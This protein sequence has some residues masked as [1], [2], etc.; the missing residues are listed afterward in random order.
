[1]VVEPPFGGMIIGNGVEIERFEN[2]LP[3]AS[4]MFDAEGILSC[5][6]PPLLSE[7]LNESKPDWFTGTGA[8]VPDCEDSWQTNGF[9]TMIVIGTEE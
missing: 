7:K 5:S 1:M 6:A 3:G 9:S 8:Y 4:E 2:G